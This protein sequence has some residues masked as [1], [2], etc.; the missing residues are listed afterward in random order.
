MPVRKLVSLFKK[1]SYISIALM[2]IAHINLG[3]ILAKASAPWWLWAITIS[4]ILIVAEIFASPWLVVKTVVYRWLKSDV[5]SFLT[6]MVFSFV[7]IVILSVFD[8][9]SY[10]L[11]VVITNAL[12]RLELQVYRLNSRQDFFGLASISLGS[13]FLGLWLSYF[14]S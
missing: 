6:T 10:V 13:L 9:F 14:L 4:F 2:S 8:I 7:M 3:L 11:L 12:V 1:N 5:G